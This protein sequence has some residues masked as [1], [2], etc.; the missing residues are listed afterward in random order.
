MSAP[1]PLPPDARHPGMLEVRPRKLRLVAA[2][3]ALVIVVVFAVLAF[4]LD[5][6][7][8]S[9]DAGLTQ[10]SWTV[11]DRASLFG[12]GVV[13]AAGLLVLTRPRVRADV[14]AVRVRNALGEKVVPWGVVAEVRFDDD[15]PWAQLELHDD[16]VIGLLAVQANDGE[17]AF[18][19]VEALRALHAA[20]GTSSGGTSSGGTSSGGTSSGGSGPA[21]RPRGAA[22]PGV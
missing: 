5:A 20:S 11:A 7:S 14:T 18:D 16:D 9:T 10:R 4:L 17:S 21:P 1:A 3:S 13:M 19:A 12:L 6:G 22:P 15:S 2:G 8:T